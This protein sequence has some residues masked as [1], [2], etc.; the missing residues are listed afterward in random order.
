MSVP[1]TLNIGPRRPVDDDLSLVTSAFDHRQVKRARLESQP[2]VVSAISAGTKPQRSWGL[3]SVFRSKDAQS[4]QPTVKRFK[5][6]AQRTVSSNKLVPKKASPTPWGR[7]ASARGQNRPPQGFAAHAATLN[8]RKEA[9]PSPPRSG[10]HN[11][12]AQ[13]AP[14]RASTPTG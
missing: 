6:T 4:D 12:Q 7:A 2:P 5:A 14:D 1:S 11:S 10:A 8:A 13:T 3:P 9:A